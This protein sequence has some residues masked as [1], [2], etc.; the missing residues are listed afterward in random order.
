MVQREELRNLHGELESEEEEEG[1]GQ[2]VAGGLRFTKSDQAV[3][4]QSSQAGNGP[5]TGF[6]DFLPHIIL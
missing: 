2:V 1:G 3:V 6:P 5:P 4:S